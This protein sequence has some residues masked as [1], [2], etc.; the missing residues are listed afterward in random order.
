[1]PRP[2]NHFLVI[3]ARLFCLTSMKKNKQKLKKM[4]EVVLEKA[5]KDGVFPLAYYTTTNLETSVRIKNNWLEVK[6]IEMDKGIRISRNFSLAECIV[7]DSVKKG[8][9]III[10]GEGIKVESNQ[11]QIDSSRFGF[12]M[13]DAST[14]RSKAL[15]IEKIAQEMKR[16]KQ[17]NGRIILVGGPA[18]VHTGAADHVA[19]IIAGKFVDVLFAGNALAVHDLERAYLGTS[20]G[21]DSKTGQSAKGGH[22]HHLRTINAI[23]YYGSIEKA[24]AAGIIT[25]GIM[26]EVTKR[27]L[28]F[29]LAGSIRDD[30][31]IPEVITDAQKAQQAM[32]QEIQKGADL[33][34]MVA[35][36]LHS[37]AVG[38]LLP[39]KVK[40]VFVDINP[41]AAIK[42]SDRGTSDSISLVTDCE[43]FFSRLEYFLN[44][45]Q[46]RNL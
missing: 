28:P 32:R 45:T 20:L 35:T 44:Q 33:V 42:L 30:G 26:Y 16:I 34:I 9:L 13:N 24:V 8:D 37:I 10:G 5:P 3:V 14:E 38:N 6:N 12:M 7:G 15:T 46:V 19:Q 29:V 31:P 23:R 36:T 43:F 2:C 40:K 25:S 41:S 18:I 11:K 4:A 39:A 21:V 22:H 1:M 17:K 27:K